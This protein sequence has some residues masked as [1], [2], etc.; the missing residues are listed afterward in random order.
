MRRAI[1]TALATSL[2][3]CVTSYAGDVALDYADIPYASVEGEAWP[4]AFLPVPEVSERYGLPEHT[5][6][7]YVELNRSGDRPLVFIHG[8]GS[9]L[10]FWRYQLDALAADGYRVIAI[11][12]LGY[13]KSD[14]PA[15]F[16][17]TME[18]M[19][20]VVHE[21]V[22]ALG[23]DKPVLVGHSMGGQTA[24]SYGIRYPKE[25]GGLV[26]TAP[27]GFERFSKK[28]KAWF[29][30]VFTVGLIKSSNEE[31]IWGSIR[32]SNFNHWHADYE[33]MIEERVRTAKNRDFN[34][35][36]YANVRSVHGLTEN[37]FVRNNLDKVKVPTVI[38]HGTA[39]RLIPNPY[40]HGGETSQIMAYGHAHIPGSTLVS[41]AGC[42]H[43]VQMDCADSYNRE[44]KKFLGSLP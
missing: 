42:G 11:D 27:A 3:S 31:A 12:M 9:Y 41:L 44:L 29:R 36:A 43:M 26:L 38:I 16:P 10:K 4:A 14:K 23:V 22:T 35:Y 40:M 18:A 28:E 25:L 39:D 32:R 34:A 6:I 5:S 37:D 15:M 13:G 33:W 30:K 2:A 21:V 8:L 19:A 1:I 17:Y 20:D 24:L 7:C